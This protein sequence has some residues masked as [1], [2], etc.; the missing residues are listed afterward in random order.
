MDSR[1]P[2]I[3]T[4]HEVGDEVLLGKEKVTI[5]QISVSVTL[6]EGLAAECKSGD[7]VAP[8]TEAGAASGSLSKDVAA[9]EKEILIAKMPQIKKGD[10]LKVGSNEKCTVSW[11]IFFS[12][13]VFDT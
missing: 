1:S 5:Q 4:P 9:G 11:L 8:V 6:S 13:F 3:R 10:A 12:R 2:Q 7:S